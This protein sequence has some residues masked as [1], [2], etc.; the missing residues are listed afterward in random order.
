MHFNEFLK[1]APKIL[2][3]E[4]PATH[5]HA[6]MVPPNREELIR[7]TDFTK[8]TPK[9]AAVMMLFYPKKFQTHLALIL[10]TSYNGVHSS[11]I[12]FPGGKV[13]LEDFDL[14]QT[15]LRET[16]EEIGVHPNSINVIRAFTEVYIPPSNYMVYP[17]LGYSHEELEF[18]LQEDE[19]AGMLE[20][21]LADFLDDGI[22]KTNPIK[23][24]YADTIDVPG[25]QVNEHFIWGATAMM[26]SELK[27]TLK[28]VL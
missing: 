11:Q 27:E 3:V 12:A 26:L 10:R 28:M 16:H 18:V 17:F 2:N 19:V 6:K 1:Y 23:T 5:A 24:S 21:P 8:I 25:F 9:K 22:L 13:E 15:A 14:K 7:N 20:F 4:L